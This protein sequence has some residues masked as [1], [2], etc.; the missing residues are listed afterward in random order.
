MG[1]GGGGGGE[2]LAVSAH[3]GGIRVGGMHA[4][5]HIVRSTSKGPIAPHYERY[6]LSCIIPVH[7]GTGVCTIVCA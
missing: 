7:C 6:A 1:V 4:C 2:V 5:C 3:F